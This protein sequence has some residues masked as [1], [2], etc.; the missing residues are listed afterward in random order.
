MCFPIEPDAPGNSHY[1]KRIATERLGVDGRDRQPV[2]VLLMGG[3][4]SVSA[5]PQVPAAI[6]KFR[7]FRTI[8]MYGRP[9]RGRVRCAERWQASIGRGADLE[10]GG[11]CVDHEQA[12]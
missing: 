9:S 4:R 7:S 10:N 3:R 2:S 1:L 11:R 5:Y 6:A 8:Q 12:N